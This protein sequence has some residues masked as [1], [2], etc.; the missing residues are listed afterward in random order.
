MQLCIVHGAQST[1]PTLPHSLSQPV[2]SSPTSCP[3]QPSVELCQDEATQLTGSKQPD[4]VCKK[5]RRKE[6]L[7]IRTVQPAQEIIQQSPLKVP[8][9]RKRAL[10]LPLATVCACG[11][12]WDHSMTMP[13][14]LLKGKQ[15]PTLSKKK[16]LVKRRPSLQPIDLEDIASVQDA[17][18]RARLLIDIA[19][20]EPKLKLEFDSSDYVPTSELSYLATPYRETLKDS[21]HSSRRCKGCRRF[22]CAVVKRK[23]GYYSRE[24]VSQHNRAN[25]CWIIVNER[26]YDVTRYL[27]K[28]PV[29]ARV[30]LDRAGTDVTT[31]MRFHSKQAHRFLDRCEIGR[32]ASC[33]ASNDNCCIS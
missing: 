4:P 17:S 16:E 11:K 20:S 3:T 28:H 19:K 7:L 15:L 10:S 18:Q 6:S 8:T 27:T 22:D 23:R 29:G 25:D 30:I 32:V 14:K 21:Q 12:P 2:L 24:Q 33:Q 26:V 5:Q 13:G 9:V 1:L 31:D